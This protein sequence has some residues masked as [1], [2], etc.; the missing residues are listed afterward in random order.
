MPML[1][2]HA[3]AGTGPAWGEELSSEPQTGEHPMPVKGLECLG[4]RAAL[5]PRAG[6]TDMPEDTA[7]VEGPLCDRARLV[8]L[9]GVVAGAGQR[10]LFIRP[11]GQPGLQGPVRAAPQGGYLLAAQQLPPAVTENEET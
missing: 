2:A 6:R 7:Q 5:R 9:P 10:C 4:L 3:K 11:T 1:G 8:A